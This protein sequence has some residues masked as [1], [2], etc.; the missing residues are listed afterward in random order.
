MIADR[1]GPEIGRFSDRAPAWLMRLGRGVVGWRPAFRVFELWRAG[2][3]LA[4]SEAAVDGLTMPGP[5]LRT[6][7]VGHANREVFLRDGRK[8]VDGVAAFLADHGFSLE[9]TAPV[10]DFGCGCGRLTRHLVADGVPVVGVD[11]NARLVRWSAANLPGVFHRCRLDPPLPLHAAAVGGVIGLS[12]FTHL[13]AERQTAWLREL[14]R[15]TAAGGWAVLSFHD[16]HQHSIPAD[17]ASAAVADGFVI[18]SG[19]LEGSN[20]YSAIQSHAQV[21]AA[22]SG[23]GWSVLAT[24]TSADTGFHQAAALLVRVES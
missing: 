16:E 24:R 22:W 9:Q 21:R 4:P 19:A 1:D 6:L 13:S 3:R 11:I 12:V 10:L 5:Y 8:A 7:V 18:R 14:A 15:V 20:L 2:W 17:V 23:A